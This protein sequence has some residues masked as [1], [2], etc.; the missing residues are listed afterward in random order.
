V[1]RSAL[2]TGAV[3]AFRRD[4]VRAATR[5]FAAHGYAAVTMRRIAVE[6][7]TSPMA[8]YRYFANKA[9]IF[10]MVRAEAYRRF[11]NEQLAAFK[12]AKAPLERLMKMRDAYVGFALRHPDEYRVM[13]ELYQEPEEL[14]PR[15]AAE[16]R[17]AFGALEDATRLAID[18]GVLE[19][20]PTTVAHLLWAQLHGLVTLHLAGK[21]TA[22]RSLADLLAAPPIRIRIDAR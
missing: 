11:A 20:D 3:E 4:T 6:L 13:F 15:L 12:S 16:S 21:L 9:E 19:G 7:G 2:T 22:D 10:A 17:R 5:L 18:A 1:P 8:P 14:H